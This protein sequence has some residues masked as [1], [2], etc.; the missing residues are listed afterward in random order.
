MIKASV[1]TIPLTVIAKILDD[2]ILAAPSIYLYLL[3]TDS[4]PINVKSYLLKWVAVSLIA[5]YIIKGTNFTF[6]SL[7]AVR[8]P[9]FRHLYYNLRVSG[10]SLLQ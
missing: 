9:G 7:I 3:S 10:L 2:D 1:R 4:C 8:F 6:E 5:S